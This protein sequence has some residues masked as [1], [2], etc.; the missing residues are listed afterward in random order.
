MQ[1]SKSCTD[2]KLKTRSSSQ[3]FSKH[4]S[5][6]S[7]KTCMRSKLWRWQKL[8]ICPPG[9][10][11][12]FPARFRLRRHKTQSIASHSVG[13]R[14][15]AFAGREACPWISLARSR[16]AGA[17]Q[18]CRAS[19]DALGWLQ[20]CAPLWESAASRISR[21]YEAEFREAWELTWLLTWACQP[22]C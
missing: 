19:L 22:G 21:V 7:T 1:L 12:G 4:L 2:P 16:A 20:R 13:I 9:S 8:V 14:Y 17:P 10:N 6:D 3:T 11:R 5:R 18:S 15:G